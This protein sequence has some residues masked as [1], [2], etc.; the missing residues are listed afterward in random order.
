MKPPITG[1]YYK[2]VQ[3]IDELEVGSL[4]LLWTESGSIQGQYHDRELNY[5]DEEFF[6]HFEFVKDGRSQRMQQLDDLMLE[7]GSA[8]DVKEEAPELLLGQ[9]SA[10][11]AGTALVTTQQRNHLVEAKRAAL[12]AKKRVEVI[13]NEIKGILAEQQKALELA[14]ESWK[15]KLDKLT[16][17]ISSINL[18]L[19]RDEEIVCIREG[20]LAP[21]SEPISIRQTVLYMDEETALLAEEG[22]LDFQSLSDFDEWVCNPKN[23]QQ[24]LPENKGIVAMRLRRESKHYANADIWEQVMMSMANGGTYILV[25][26]GEKLWRIWNEIELPNHLFP[27]A[28]EFNDLFLDSWSKE[29]IRPGSRKYQKA[30]DEANGVQKRYLQAVLILQGLL[31]RTQIFKPLAVE[32]VNLLDQSQ[33]PS[34]VRLIRDAENLLGSGKCDYR[35]W[36]R[37]L[38]QNLEVG[39]RIVF[40]GTEHQRYQHESRKEG[41]SRTHPKFVNWPDQNQ[42]YTV[43]G[44]SKDDGDFT[45]GYPT[46]SAKWGREDKPI[47]GVFHFYRSDDFILNF[48]DALESDIVFYMSDRC[49]R[50]HYLSSFPL[51][52]AALDLKAK[53]ATTEAPFVDLLVREACSKFKVAEAQTTI[54][55]RTIIRWWKQKNRITRSLSASENLAYKQILNEVKLRLDIHQSILSEDAVSR[56]EAAGKNYLVIAKDSGKSITCLRQVPGIKGLV[57]REIWDNRGLVCKNVKDWY[58]PDSE[59]GRWEILVQTEDWVAWPKH[60]RGSEFLTEPEIQQ[61]VSDFYAISQNSQKPFITKLAAI[62]LRDNSLMIYGMFMR[63]YWDTKQEEWG[64]RE[65]KWTR[66]KGVAT[67]DHYYGSWS[68]LTCDFATTNKKVNEDSDEEHTFDYEQQRLNNLTPET[69]K[70]PFTAYGHRILFFDEASLAEIKKRIAIKAHKRQKENQRDHNLRNLVENVGIEIDKRFWAWEREKY[71]Q[72]GGVDDLWEDHKKTVKYRQIDLRKTELED[73]LA[74]LLRHITLGAIT[75]LTVGQMWETAINKGWKANHTEANSAIP[76]NIQLQVTL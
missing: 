73:C 17:A 7:A 69:R 23:L 41:Y 6:T 32:R 62:T 76:A 44:L 66:V 19:G 21:V 13:K 60:G 67:L 11:E 25:R 64:V 2:I 65:A 57:R 33:D 9:G 63:T 54:L 49:N 68:S 45:F 38:N 53:E 24:L 28:K 71:L 58:M 20:V 75:E 48:D 3:P 34:L 35:E 5:S 1:A 74:Y 4:L 55:I 12:T 10:T 72:D 22:G 40:G 52:Q 16:Y 70:L 56:I 46:K 26:N 27:T 14:S 36:L 30:L 59:T 47:K 43:S 37:G 31:D 29:Q 50:H 42:V 8:G 18:Y 61:L 51:L 39:K 15:A